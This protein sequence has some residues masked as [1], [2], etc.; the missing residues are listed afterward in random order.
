MFVPTVDDNI[1]PKNRKDAP[2]LIDG[3]KTVQVKLFLIQ[4]TEELQCQVRGEHLW[5]YRRR[6]KSEAEM[7]VC[8]HYIVAA[9]RT[10]SG[11]WGVDD[12]TDGTSPK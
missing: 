1:F 4:G 11:F 8:L 2:Q 10:V 6:D 12:W 5:R 7:F 3:Y 9:E